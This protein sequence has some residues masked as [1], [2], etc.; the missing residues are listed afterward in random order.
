MMADDGDDAYQ[1]VFF[2]VS[3][4]GRNAAWTHADLRSL[5]RFF[6]RFA[7]VEHFLLLSRYFLDLKKLSRSGLT[8]GLT[9]QWD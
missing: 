8:A 5:W 6:R 1:F 2:R 3:Y 7:V 9:N 4:P